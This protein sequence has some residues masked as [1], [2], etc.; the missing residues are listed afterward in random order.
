MQEKMLALAPKQSLRGVKK[1]D[2][3]S[4]L[5]YPEAAMINELNKNLIV[6]IDTAYC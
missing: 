1:H 6:S 4:G 3:E 5:A 2:A